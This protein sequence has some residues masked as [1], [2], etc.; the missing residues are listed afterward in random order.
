MTTTYRDIKADMMRR[1]TGGEWP[2][3]SLLPNE[4]ELCDSYGSA[5]ATVGRALRELVDEGII[6]RKRKSGTRVRAA[7]LRQMRMAIPL[8]RAE[9]EG[10]G[11]EYRYAQIRSAVAVPPPGIAARMALAE[12]QKA[13]H[14][15]ALHLADGQPY[16]LEDRWINIEAQPEAET[17][18]FT[19]EGPNE[20]LVRQAPYTDVE[21][22]MLAVK[23]GADLSQMLGCPEGTALFRVER[24]TF[25]EG[26][27]VTLVWL[28]Y[29]QGHRMVT[30][31]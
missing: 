7:P 5:R 31:Y 20:W 18:D 8:V 11:A 1:I 26:R 21:V 16:Q 10:Q 4:L 3:G 15:L 19:A 13:R 29:H 17:A 12:G 2:P 22:A 6:E 27:T 14:V 30:R 25:W 24:L 23:A 28:T 9:I